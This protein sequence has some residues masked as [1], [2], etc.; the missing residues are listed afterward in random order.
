MKRENFIKAAEKYY[1]KVVTMLVRRDIDRDVAQDAVQDAFETML[2]N[3]VYDKLNFEAIDNRVFSYLKRAARSEV[4]MAKRRENIDN[5]IFVSV[6]N[7]TEKERD[8]KVDDREREK[9]DLECPFCHVGIL[10]QFKA[11]A[12]CRTILG[13]GKTVR[14]HMTVDEAD[15]AS[16]P[17]L[18]KE[19]DVENAIQALEPLEQKVIRAIVNGTDTLDGLAD[20]HGMSRDNLWRTYVRAKKKLQVAL[21]EYS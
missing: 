6:E 5:G 8:E 10:N 15:L 21:L 13:Q 16:L 3:K 19:I 14:E 18:D 11:C 17:D 9:P 1:D 20:A 7:E 4:A 2:R 12:T